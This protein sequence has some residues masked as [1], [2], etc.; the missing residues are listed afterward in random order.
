[1]NEDIKRLLKEKKELFS[2][3]IKYDYDE[4]AYLKKEAYHKLELL[5]SIEDFMKQN[6]ELRSL[7]TEIDKL[8]S[9]SKNKG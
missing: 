5:D 7:L 4:L 3:N 9:S 8:I 6:K 1:M 2:K